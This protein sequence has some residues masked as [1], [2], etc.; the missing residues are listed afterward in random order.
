MRCAIAALPRNLRADDC[1]AFFIRHL[2][3]AGARCPYCGIAASGRQVETFNAGGRLCCNSCHRWFTYRTG[4]PLQG[5]KTDDRQVFLLVAL[6]AAGCLPEI[7]AGICQFN[8]V[9]TVTKLQRR[10][11]EWCA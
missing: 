6:T 7:V 2:H 10:F 1:R 8:D 3:P 5:V 9:A 11:R 4:T